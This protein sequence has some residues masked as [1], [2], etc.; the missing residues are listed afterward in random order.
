M[1][2]ITNIC[3]I[4]TKSVKYI[5]KLLLY[6][7]ISDNV[8][9]LNEESF[10]G[11][12]VHYLND[13][14]KTNNDKVNVT[15]TPE[16]GNILKNLKANRIN[17]LNNLKEKQIEELLLALRT[18]TGVINWQFRKIIDVI[19]DECCS[20]INVWD[21]SS[22]LKLLNVYVQ[23]IPCQVAT[24]K[25][26]HTALTHISKYIQYLNREEILQFVFYVGLPKGKSKSKQAML[27][28]CLKQLT[29]NDIRTLSIEELCII[30]NATFRSSTKISNGTILEKI[31]EMLNENLY[32]LRDPALLVTLIKTV[33]HNRYQ[34]DDLL[35]TLSCAIMFNRTIESYNFMTLCHVMAL[36][37]DYGF[38]HGTLLKLYLN[39]CLKY[40]KTDVSENWQHR[41]EEIRPKDITRFLWILSTL[42]YDDDCGIFE[43]IVVPTIVRKIERGAYEND[44]E[45]LINSVL[46]LWML[47]YQA[48]ALLPIIFTQENVDIVKGKS[49]RHVIFDNFSVAW[50]FQFAFISRSCQN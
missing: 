29:S 32:L 45:E 20:R 1:N 19:D 2:V 30:C 7:R 4:G 11:R 15:P 50:E 47:D 8:P 39:E 37:V 21:I 5:N 41:P 48:V 35:N 23:V 12:I 9:A 49:S 33:R 3:T 27:K 40:L 24:N 10:V 17:T 22:L 43:E 42:G 31:R 28:A 26:F 25:F 18:P 46:Y 13:Y 38:Y 36:F 34:D 16:I 6:R 44:T 14:N